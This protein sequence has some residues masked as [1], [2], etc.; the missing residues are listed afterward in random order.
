MKLEME[1]SG[2]EGGPRKKGDYYDW[3]EV[4]ICLGKLENKAKRSRGMI[5][6]W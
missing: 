3:G 4:F 2:R 5:D 6:N 1:E